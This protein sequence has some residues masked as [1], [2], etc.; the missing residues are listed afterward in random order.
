MMWI[1]LLAALIVA[2]VLIYGSA[3]PSAFSVVREADIKASPA[4]VF[5]QINDFHHWSAWSPWEKLDPAMQRS[6]SGASSGVGAKYS[7]VGNKKVGEGNMEITASEP[8]RRM[9]LDLH[10]IKP[11]Q[12]DNVTEFTLS[13][14]TG[15]TH[16][17]WEMRGHKPFMMRVMGLVMDMDKMVGKDFEAGL[18][19][20]RAQ[21]EK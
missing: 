11:F 19:N 1:L 16:V 15:G 9:Q 7:W 3:Q 18:A 4:E 17:K 21:V 5:A 2:F 8:A 13:P 12:A 10:F 20:L 14:A 6:F